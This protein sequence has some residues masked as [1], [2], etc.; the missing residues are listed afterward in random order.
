M[1]VAASEVETKDLPVDGRMATSLGGGVVGGAMF[2]D[3]RGGAVDG[4]S[5]SFF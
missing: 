4:L 2:P 5:S 3:K 1:P